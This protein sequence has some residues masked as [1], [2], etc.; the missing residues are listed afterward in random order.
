MNQG[1]GGWGGGGGWGAYGYQGGWG[2]PGPGWGQG[3]GGPR[4]PGGP[5]GYGGQGFPGPGGPGG[6]GPQAY[7]NYL[8]G[9]QQQGNGGMPPPPGEEEGVGGD[10]EQG[11]HQQNQGPSPAFSMAQNAMGGGAQAAGFGNWNQGYGGGNWPRPMGGY[12]GGFN[13]MPPQISQNKKN[14]AKKKLGQQIGGGVAGVP[15]PAQAQ[16]SAQLASQQPGGAAQTDAAPGVTNAS[17]TENSQEQKTSSLPGAQDW[18]PS[19]KAYVS[20]CFNACV[21]TEHKD[22]VEIILK[23]KI[24]AA[25]TTNSLW[26]KEWDKEDLPGVLAKT[27]KPQGLV[28]DLGSQGKVVRG[29]LMGRT[30]PAFGARPGKMEDKNSPM[31]GGRRRQRP[32]DEDSPDFG[33]NANMVPLGGGKGKQLGGNKKDKK[34]KKGAHFYTNPMSMELDNDLGSS[35]MKQKRMARFAGDP[36]A[37]RKKPMNLLSTL[38][39]RLLNG[40]QDW[41]ISDSVDWEKMHIVG[42]MTKLEKPFLRLTEAPEAS[43]VRPVHVLRR[44]VAMVKEKWLQAQDYHYA[45]DQLK[46]IR[47]DLTVQGVRDTF[48]VSVYETHARVALEKGDFT[49]FNQCQSQLKM[50]Y[51]DIGGDN[52]LEFTAYRILYY[53]YTQVNMQHNCHCYI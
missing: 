3:W 53:I 27:Q 6:Y 44:A 36:A 38:N 20:K 28:G 24:T 30:H 43:K 15:N 16:V 33:G 34:A 42:T 50:L 23:G 52:R 4:F 48:T 46:S 40:D 32:S 1:Q 12:Q 37:K 21:T 51:H 39:D 45:C 9:S 17:G 26:T 22:M 10:G 18:P 8:G 19:L 47:Q 14:K 35:Q 2:Q 31:K 7:E 29:G 49:E 25:A 5:G 41:E 13:P 11:N